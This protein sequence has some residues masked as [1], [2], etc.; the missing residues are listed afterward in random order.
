MSEIRITLIGGADEF[1]KKL[2]LTNSYVR[3]ELRKGLLQ[4]K[5]K[6]VGHKKYNEKGR[7]TQ[8]LAQ[9]SLRYKSGKWSRAAAGAFMGH[10]IEIPKQ[11]NTANIQLDMG[12]LSKGK[13]NSDNSNFIQ[14]LKLLATGGSISSSK[15]MP[16]PNYKN[17]KAAGLYQ[18]G[19]S[20]YSLYKSI[21]KGRGRQDIFHGNLN[22]QPAIF[23]RT[24]GGKRSKKLLFIGAKRVRL[25][26]VQYE[27]ETGFNTFIGPEIQY[28]HNRLDRAI[29][30]AE[31]K[32]S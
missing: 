25:P 22:G 14:G 23:M 12:I 9:K 10:M 6:W 13:K 29:R 1:R 27:F 5:K 3:A 32:G 15:F 19:I 31:R 28:L 21:A 4:I 18:S 20:S 16:V 2:I 11:G 30:S 17:L 7:Y 26:Q 8:R 24:P